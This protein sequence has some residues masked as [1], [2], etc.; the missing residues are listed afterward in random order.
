MPDLAVVRDLAAL[1]DH[2]AVLATSRKDGTV[3]ASLVKAGVLDHPDTGEAS[4]GIVVGGDARK[5]GHLRTTGQATIV[6]SRGA[7]WVAVDGPVRITEADEGTERVAPILR[8]VYT[9]AGGTHDDWDQFDRAMADEG[10]CAVL[11]AVR[12]ITRN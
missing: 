6:F 10:R 11:V 4:V 3:H 7:R 1:A 9:A 12:R 2:F 5:L 8:S